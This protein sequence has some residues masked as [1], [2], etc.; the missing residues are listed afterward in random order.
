MGKAY[1]TFR[2]VLEDDYYLTDEVN[3]DQPSIEEALRYAITRWEAEDKLRVD[4]RGESL[5]IRIYRKN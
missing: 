5:T 1:Y 3:T 2:V 4:K